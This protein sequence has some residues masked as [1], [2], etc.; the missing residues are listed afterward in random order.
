MG[1]L[2]TNA[3][4]HHVI[5]SNQLVVEQ[6]PGRVYK[7]STVAGFVLDSLSE[8]GHE[9]VNP[10][11]LVVGDEHEKGEEGLP[12]GSRLLL[13]DFPLMGGKESWASLK[14]RVI[15]L[16]ITL[17]DLLGFRSQTGAI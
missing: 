10:V 1:S 13:V 6:K 15:T 2:C 16:G 7:F 5:V 3:N 11:Q 12:D 9:G 17:V 4:D 8:D 14:R